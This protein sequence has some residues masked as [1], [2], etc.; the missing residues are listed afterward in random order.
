[1]LVEHQ[2]CDAT[3]SPI[4]AFPKA[5]SLDKDAGLLASASADRT[6]RSA[7]TFFQQRNKSDDASNVV[8]SCRIPLLLFYLL[9]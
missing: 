7:P 4:V 6:D 8:E 3:G 1:L 5:L 9:W 2:K